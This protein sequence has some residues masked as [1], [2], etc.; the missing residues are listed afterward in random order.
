MNKEEILA[1]SRNENKDADIFE[2][3]VLKTASNA[4]V[5]AA[6]IMAGVLF[7]FELIL[8]DHVN[9]SLWSIIFTMSAAM[10]TVKAIK[11]KRAHEIVLAVA[12]S[13]LAGIMAV[14][15]IVTLFENAA[16]K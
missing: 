10:F 13:L 3:E 12:D 5:T 15:Y 1:R 16:V 9:Y 7:L 14:Q 11:L 4:S 2:K 6:A 8:T